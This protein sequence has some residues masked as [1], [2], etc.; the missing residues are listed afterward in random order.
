M[1]LIS[2]T[3]FLE[4]FKICTRTFEMFNVILKACSIRVLQELKQSCFTDP[5][6]RYYNTELHSST[7][8][9]SETTL[10]AYSRRT[11][12]WKRTLIGG[13]H[14]RDSFK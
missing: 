5:R 3:V 13:Q 7:T 2:S 6:E 14:I 10:C 12:S 11:L 9:F 8:M 4:K 1:K